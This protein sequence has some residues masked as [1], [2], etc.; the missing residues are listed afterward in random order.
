MTAV[1]TECIKLRTMPALQILLIQALQQWL[2]YDPSSD[3]P[4]QMSVEGFTTAV[5]RV[6]FHQNAI[7]WDHIFQGRFSVSWGILQDE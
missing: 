1:T 3:I 7:G 5:R 6:I 2:V 4:F